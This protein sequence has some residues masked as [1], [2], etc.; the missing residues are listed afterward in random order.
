MVAVCG[1]E[2]F[3]A[4]GVSLAAVCARAAPSNEGPS[5]GLPVPLVVRSKQTLRFDG[6]PG[7]S[8]R[9]SVAAGSHAVL[10]RPSA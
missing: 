1:G 4:A 2:R 9:A 5:H 7:T 8:R 6:A 10:L 3:L